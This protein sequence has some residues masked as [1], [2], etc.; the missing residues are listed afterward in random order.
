[1]HTCY[2][3]CTNEA[4]ILDSQISITSLGSCSPLHSQGCFLAEQMGKRA[5]LD[6]WSKY[7]YP[8]IQNITFGGWV[9][10]LLAD[11]MF[12]SVVPVTVSERAVRLSPDSDLWPV[13]TDRTRPV[14]KN[15]LWNLTDVDRTLAPRVRSLRCSASDQLPDPDQHPVSTDR[16]RAIRNFPLWNLSRVDR[17]LA[18]SV[19]SL[20]PQRSVATRWL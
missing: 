12:R 14:K 17:T 6:E 15:A 19:R 2:S 7:L 3:P 20:F 18:P 10:T 8:L 13:S 5:L 9:T 4:L 1:M 16:T 11:R